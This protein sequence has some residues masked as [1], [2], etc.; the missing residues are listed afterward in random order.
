MRIGFPTAAAAFR[1]ANVPLYAGKNPR[2]L[3]TAPLETNTT[4]LFPAPIAATSAA[5]F[6]IVAGTIIPCAFVTTAVPNLMTITGFCMRQKYPILTVYTTYTCCMAQPTPQVIAN[7]GIGQTPA[8][9]NAQRLFFRFFVAWFL[10]YIFFN[11]NGILPGV[12]ETFNFYIA[13]F[14]RLI[15]WIG[16]HLL[17]MSK[18]ISIFTNGSGDTTYDY[19][20]L[21][22][23]LCITILA[24][25]T[26]SLLDRRKSYNKLFYWVTT[27]LRYYLG[28]TMLTYGFAKVFKMQFP[29]PSPYRLLEPFGDSTPMGLAWTYMGYSTGYNLFT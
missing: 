25:I 20:T 1:S 7:S 5:T 14:H 12:D 18:P 10:L 26:W 13:P 24:T 23:I 29:S 21:L 16:Q 11:P 6:R 3:P 19:V 9:T 15:P 22:L 28:I 17:R 27:I 4:L 8:W 2:P